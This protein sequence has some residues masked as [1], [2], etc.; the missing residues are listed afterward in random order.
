MNAYTVTFIH[1]GIE[2]TTEINQPSDKMAQEAGQNLL[3]ALP[4]ASTSN[5]MHW[6][7]Y[8]STLVDKNGKS[9]Y[10]RIVCQY[11]IVSNMLVEVNVT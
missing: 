3:R 11:R 2:W 1:Q 4:F 8:L 9:T 7:G 6:P 5:N 10:G